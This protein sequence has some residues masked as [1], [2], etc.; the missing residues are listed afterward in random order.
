MCIAEIGG[1]VEPDWP[2]AKFMGF[3]KEKMLPNEM[4]E[5]RSFFPPTVNV[6]H[7]N[8]NWLR[9]AMEGTKWEPMRDKVKGSNIYVFV[10]T[11]KDLKPSIQAYMKIE[12]QFG[13][14]AKLDVLREEW[15][16]D[17]TYDLQPMI[18]GMMSEEWNVMEPADVVKLKDFPTKTELIGQ[19]AG[20][21]KQVTTKLAVGVKQVPTKLAIGLKKT[22]EKGEED[23]KRPGPGIDTSCQKPKHGQTLVSEQQSWAL[24]A[25]KATKSAEHTPAV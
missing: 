13:R 16:D 10:E 24:L 15:A 3:N 21:I 18:G 9:K 5:A 8:N 25:Q 4:E 6:R 23:G 7:L 17:L 20:S 1:T 14:T 12:K 19:I 22:V 2:N 11:D